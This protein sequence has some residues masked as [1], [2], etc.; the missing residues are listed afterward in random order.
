MCKLAPAEQILIKLQHTESDHH[1]PG[2]KVESIQVNI[3]KGTT[4]GRVEAQPLV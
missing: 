3:S 4:V 2:A 1:A